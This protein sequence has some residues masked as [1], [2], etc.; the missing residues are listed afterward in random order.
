MDDRP[1]WGKQRE[2]LFTIV[3]SCIG[4]GNV[5][6]FPYLWIVFNLIIPFIS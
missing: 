3:G 1:K 4:L 6:R 5:W 2:F